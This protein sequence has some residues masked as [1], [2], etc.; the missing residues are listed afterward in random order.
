MRIEIKQ[1]KIAIRIIAKIKQ[2]FFITIV[3]I[4]FLLGIYIFPISVY[5]SGK[6]VAWGENDKGECTVPA[7]DNDFNTLAAGWIHSLGLKTNG[8]IVAWGDNEYGQC[9]VPS[10]NTG[11]TAIAAG[12]WHSLGLRQNGSIAAWGYNNDG[13]C[14]V[15]SPNTDFIVISAGLYYSLGLKQDGSIVA[16]GYN[17]DG[18]CD[19]PLPN[20]G[21][22]AIASGGFHS[23]GLKADGSIVAW[24]YNNDGQCNIPSPNTGFTAIS[25][26][27]YYSLGLKQDGSIV[28]WGDNGS[29]QCTL[30][31]PNIGFTAIAAGADHSLGLKRNG[32]IVTW[33]DNYYGE[34]AVPSPNTSFTAI[35]A[36]WFHS[37]GLKS[38]ITITKCTITA[39]KTQ[40]QDTFSASGAIVFPSDLDFNNVNHIDVNIISLTDSASIYTET[41]DSSVIKGKFQYTH[42]IPSGGTGAITSLVVDST[43]DTFSINAQNVDFTGL[44]CPLQLELT[45]GG[46][47]LYGDADESVVNGGKLILTCLMRLYKDTLVVN[48]AK[49]KHNSKKASSDTLSVMGNIAVKNMDLNTNEPNLVTENVVLTWGD[50]NGIPTKTITIPYGS[51]KTS[52]AGHVYN[53]S[54]IHPTGDPD[55][56][57]AAQFDLDKCAFTVFVSKASNVFTGHADA[58]FGVSFATPNGEFYQAVDVN[59]FTGRS[60]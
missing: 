4:C 60:W 47:K 56:L 51:F 18:E 21:F 35:G 39:G 38:N 42:K 55:S 29:G 32:S 26:G 25:A 28:A 3:S 53:C 44:A 6:I 12:W 48:K 43:K 59:H 11:F 8:S 13:E 15:P 37:L 16:W 10:P 41:V 23:L 27:W 9:N 45:I 31:S 24:G 54:K 22:T 46:Y 33:G 2:Y 34:C 1:K 17:D 57:I 30:P 40:G 19:V 52:K 20:T 49:A 14:N 50:I 58:N 5:A 7:P 36:G